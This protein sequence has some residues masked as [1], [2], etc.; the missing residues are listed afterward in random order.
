MAQSMRYHRPPKQNYHDQTPLHHKILRS[1]AHAGGA[2]T[3]KQ[4]SANHQSNEIT[5]HDSVTQFLIR[6][7]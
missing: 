3:F 7:P 2:K 1:R 5:T 6:G 4:H